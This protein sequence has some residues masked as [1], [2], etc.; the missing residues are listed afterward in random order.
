MSLI[1]QMRS[2][3]RNGHGSSEGPTLLFAQY[4]AA[5]AGVYVGQS[6][7]VDEKI[8]LAFDSLAENSRSF[9]GQ[10]DSLSM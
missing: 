10:R 1:D 2:Y 4:G 5:T 3:L 6:L 7:R 9:D 8:I